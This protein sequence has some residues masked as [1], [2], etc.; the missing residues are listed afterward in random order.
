MTQKPKT[1]TKQNIG[2]HYTPPL[3]IFT[4]IVATEETEIKFISGLDIKKSQAPN[5]K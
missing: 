2:G 1:Y 5:H 4:S 3:Y